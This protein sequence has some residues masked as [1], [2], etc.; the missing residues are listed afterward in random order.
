M[1]VMHDGSLFQISIIDAIMCYRWWC[2]TTIGAMVTENE[3]LSNDSETTVILFISAR[4]PEQIVFVRTGGNLIGATRGATPK[5][6]Y[7][8]LA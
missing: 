4:G 5:D 7:M 3:F 6:L 2:R 1:A 8:R